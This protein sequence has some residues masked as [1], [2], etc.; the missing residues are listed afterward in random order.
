MKNLRAVLFV[1]VLGG[2]FFCSTEQT[3][4]QPPRILFVTYDFPVPTHQYITNQI[5]G[6]INHGYDV[7]IAAKYHVKGIVPEEVQQYNLL[8]R[9][10]FFGGFYSFEQALENHPI[11][12]NLEEFDIIWCQFGSLGPQITKIKKRMM[13]KKR[14]I[15]AKIVA[16]FRGS[17]ATL[18][19]LQN[20]H[21]YDHFFKEG[22][23]S[24]PVSHYFKEHLIKLGCDPHKIKVLYSTVDCNRFT[25]R[26]RLL[27]EDK[28]VQIIS[29]SRLF[30]TKGIKY[31]I[32]A[33]AQLVKKYP[34]IR[35]T[36]VGEGALK[37]ELEK[38]VA[39][40]NM[41]QHIVFAGRYANEDIH[42]DL[43]GN[44]APQFGLS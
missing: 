8:E 13:Q 44:G 36:I 17:D 24:L 29:V 4:G 14:N 18:R 11:V 6:A 1:F 37:E 30:E 7:Y 9:T 28:P 39:T 23:L 21:M 43:I 34:N 26:K 5:I 33:V 12:P 19:P 32:Y 3:S 41:Q 35:Y 15:K 22:D 27:Q 16:C 31:T 25:Y 10:V 20:P 2:T 42:L 38:L 40:L